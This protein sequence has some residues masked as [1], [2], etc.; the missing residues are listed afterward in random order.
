MQ[1][2][3]IINKIRK[4]GLDK[5]ETEK[6]FAWLQRY[7]GIIHTAGAYTITNIAFMDS[8]VLR[9]AVAFKITTNN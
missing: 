2:R 7:K 5:K 1:K 4:T 3:T 6:A 8:T 9:N